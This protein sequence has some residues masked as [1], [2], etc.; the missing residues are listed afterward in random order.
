MFG[1]KDNICVAACGSSVHEY[2]I[3][4]LIAAGARKILLAFDKEGQTPEEEIKYY[5]KLHD[6]CNR[7]KNKV[8]MGYIRDMD[9]LLNLKDSPT[10]KGKETFLK[11]YWRNT[12]WL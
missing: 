2:Q 7:Y 10:D 1:H 3:N 4:L 5:N 11:L 9:N 6:I 12:V 8:Q